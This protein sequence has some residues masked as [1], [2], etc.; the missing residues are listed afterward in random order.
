MLQTE[1]RAANPG[2]PPADGFSNRLT[3]GE[4]VLIHPSIPR[5]SE[6]REYRVQQVEAGRIVL[7]Q[8]P[9]DPTLTVT[10]GAIAELQSARGQKPAMLIL[11]G[12]LQWITA[13]REWA[14]LPEEPPADS[15]HGLHKLASADDPGVLDLIEEL[16]RKGYSAWWVPAGS[17]REFLGQGGE[18][19]YDSD[20]RYL[21]TRDQRSEW[22]LLGR[23]IE[24]AASLL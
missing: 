20:G 5:P 1:G 2:Y 11:K 23:S 15:E 3:P 9:A 7:R 21:R 22:V 13:A 8:R 24:A 16:R 10:T 18:I 4:K 19:I 12:R 6:H 14:V 17:V